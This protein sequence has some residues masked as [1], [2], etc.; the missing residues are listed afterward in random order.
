MDSEGLSVPVTYTADW[1]GC[2][3]VVTVLFVYTN[4]SGCC[5]IVYG[6]KLAINR[7]DCWMIEAQICL[8]ADG[9]SS[10]HQS[11]IAQIHSDS[12]RR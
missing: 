11:L 7:Y 3:L 5:T 9:G 10:S 12:V 8:G 1:L 6:D 4:I 2:Q